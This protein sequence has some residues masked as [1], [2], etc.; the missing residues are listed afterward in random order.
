MRCLCAWRQ[1]LTVERGSNAVFECLATM[2]FPGTGKQCG[3]RVPGD[4]ACP[5][6]GGEMR[7]LCAWDH[8]L[9]VEQG[10]NALFVCLATMLDR[11]AGGAMRCLCAWRLC[12]VVEHESN[13]VFVR[14]ATMPDRG[15][16]EQCAV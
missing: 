3:V 7:C 12:P 9:S 5:G 4:N 15:A 6:S 2:L 11:G 8:A 16:G 14:L 13:A 1:C 10:S